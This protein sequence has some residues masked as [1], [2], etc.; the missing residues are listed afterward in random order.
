MFFKVPEKP[1]KLNISIR[2]F[3]SDDSTYLSAE[4][5]GTDPDELELQ[6]IKKF[7]ELS[8]AL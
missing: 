8:K 2:I 1:R 4:F 7:K 3:R 5:N 6:L